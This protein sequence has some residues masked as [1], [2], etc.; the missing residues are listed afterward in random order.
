MSTL[1]M[2]LDRESESPLA[3]LGGLLAILRGAEAP[4]IREALGVDQT[5]SIL[6]ISTEGATDP[7]AY[8]RVVSARG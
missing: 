3:G 2:P 6:V 4:R 8:A 1:A 5:S 7:E